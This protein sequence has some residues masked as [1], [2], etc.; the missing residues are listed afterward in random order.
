MLN[1]SI[2]RPT[3]ADDWYQLKDKEGK[4]IIRISAA[5]S[6]AF[7]LIS[8]CQMLMTANDAPSRPAAETTGAIQ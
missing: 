4:V 2:V 1:Y 6:N 8:A 7:Y 3:G 5:L